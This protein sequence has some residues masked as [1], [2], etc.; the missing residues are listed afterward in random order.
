MVPGTR[1]AKIST[2]V[3]TV[4]STTWRTSVFRDTKAAPYLLNVK[5]AACEAGSLVEGSGVE[6]D[7]RPIDT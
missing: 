3:S 4:G 5:R 6:L 1:P 7:L 2:P